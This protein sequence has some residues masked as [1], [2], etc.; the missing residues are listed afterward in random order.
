MGDEVIKQIDAALQKYYISLNRRDYLDANGNGKFLIHCEDNGF[1]DDAIEE[2][3]QADPEECMVIDF[4][5][6][7]PFPANNAPENEKDQLKY[8]LTILQKCYNNPNY[9]GISSFSFQLEKNHFNVYHSNPN[10][11]KLTEIFKL[12]CPQICDKTQPQGDLMKLL[13]I[14]QYI[15]GKPYLHLLADTYCR[16][17]IIHYLQIK[18]IKEN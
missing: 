4:D 5:D 13:Y 14:S 9:N 16:D 18:I 8:I 11:H 12:Y 1:D 6:N 17:R 3:L 2:E 7:F 15:I 10:W